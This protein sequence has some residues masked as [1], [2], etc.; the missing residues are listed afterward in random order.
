[1]LFSYRLV[2]LAEDTQNV[3]GNHPP[4]HHDQDSGPSETGP[5]QSFPA[6]EVKEWISGLAG[7]MGWPGGLQKDRGVSSSQILKVH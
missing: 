3:Q 1:M 7:M 2:L 6:M 5:P 4:A